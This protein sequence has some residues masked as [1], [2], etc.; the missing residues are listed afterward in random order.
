M[1]SLRD[2]DD[3]VTKRIMKLSWRKTAVRERAAENEQQRKNESD[4]EETR[5]GF[6]SLKWFSECETP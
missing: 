3:G 5:I 2:D 1:V 4:G 6:I